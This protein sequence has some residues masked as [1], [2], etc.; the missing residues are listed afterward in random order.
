MG[1]LLVILCICLMSALIFVFHKW[2]QK[3]R[4]YVYP[5]QKEIILELIKDLN[6]SKIDI[7]LSKIGPDDSS[8]LL[9]LFEARKF[10]NN[11]RELSLEQYDDYKLFFSENNNQ[12]VDFK[13]YSN[14][15]LPDEILTEL[16]NFYNA[17]YTRVYPTGLYFIVVLESRQENWDTEDNSTGLF[18]GNGRAFETWLNFKESADNLSYVITQ[19]IRENCELT[20]IELFERLEEIED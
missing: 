17:H 9:T 5:K 16:E 20:D 11:K 12:V 1:A 14:K 18:T 6:S 8:V 4:K 2:R 7:I 10:L 15:F 13:K 19:W 3:K